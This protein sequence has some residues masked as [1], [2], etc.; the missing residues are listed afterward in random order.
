[1]ATAKRTKASEKQAICKKLVTVLKKRYSAKFSN[2]S[3]PV[4]ETM[5]YGICLENANVDAADQ[6]YAR[7]F[8]QF[9]DFNEIRVSSV[10]EIEPVFEGMADADWR[11]LR[12][13]YVLQHVFE[14][15]Y[16]FD[17][18]HLKRKTHDLANKH[19]SKIKYLTPFVRFFTL[20]QTFGSHLVPADDCMCNAAIWLGLLEPKVTTKTA[21]EALKSAVRKS[22]VPLFAHMLR[23]LACDPK[24]Q[25]AF[26]LENT[27][28]PNEGFDTAQSPGRLPELFK[29]GED[30]AK[31]KPK[32]K[33]TA[34]TKKTQ[35]KKVKTKKVKKKA[36]KHSAASRTAKTKKK[37]TIKKKTVKKPVKKKSARVA[38]K[39]TRKKK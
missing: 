16:A 24:L 4:L 18:D 20:H 33:K 11:G 37:S 32:K 12:A 28:V 23:Q 25:F 31:R 8:A 1:M 34:T 19:L 38:K 26:D 30:R 22:D 27:D 15:R 7:L 21:S 3:R 6:A 39:T 29:E 13:R 9:H 17:F 2:E 35:T 36:T 5:L 10:R 14:K